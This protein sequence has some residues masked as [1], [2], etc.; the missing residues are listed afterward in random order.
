[1]FDE[2]KEEEIFPN[3]ST[4]QYFQRKMDGNLVIL[5]QTPQTPLMRGGEKY[6][7]A[8]QHRTVFQPPKNLPFPFPKATNVPG[9]SHD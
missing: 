9:L 7:T 5:F 3:D 8:R 1:M 4:P 6:D 2:E